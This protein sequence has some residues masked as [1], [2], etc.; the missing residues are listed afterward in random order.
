MSRYLE[1]NQ[2]LYGNNNNQSFAYGDSSVGR[3]DPLPVQYPL[4]TGSV[5][6]GDSVTSTP[7]AQGIGYASVTP[8]IVPGSGR[9]RSAHACQLC[10]RQ[11]VSKLVENSFRFL[12]QTF[13]AS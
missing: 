4:A 3:I 7:S 11:K 9:V 6:R 13:S 10:R 1:S 12:P 2:D 5:I 8:P